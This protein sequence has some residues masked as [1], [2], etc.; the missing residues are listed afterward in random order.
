MYVVVAPDKLKGSLTAEQAAAAIEAGLRRVVP[1]LDVRRCPV[2]DGGDGTVAAA[3]SR[4]WERRTATGSGP[5]GGPA[6]AGWAQPDGTGLV[7]LAEANG[8]RHAGGRP[9][10]ALPPSRGTGEPG[11]APLD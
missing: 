5:F 10:A 4:G 9:D 8:L 1:D 2:A 3:I 11:P 6:H 7:Q